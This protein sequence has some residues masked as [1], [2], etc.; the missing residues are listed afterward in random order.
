[1]KQWFLMLR[2][3]VVFLALITASFAQTLVEGDISGVWNMEGSPYI[4]T[5]SVCVPAEDTLFIEPGVEV[6][7]RRLN[8]PIMFYVLGCLIAHGTEEDSI[9]FMSNEDEPR[10]ADWKYIYA[11]EGDLDLSYLKITDSNSGIIGGGKLYVSHCKIVNYGWRTLPGVISVGEPMGICIVMESTVIIR[12]CYIDGSNERFSGGIRTFS[13]I[14][15]TL[16]IENCIIKHTDEKGIGLG[17]NNEQEMSVM[18]ISDCVLEDCGTGIGLGEFIS[19]IHIRNNMFI[20]CRKFGFGLSRCRSRIVE[21]SDNTFYR[22]DNINGTAITIYFEFSDDEDVEEQTGEFRIRNNVINGWRLGLEYRGDWRG[23]DLIREEL[24]IHFTNNTVV[25]GSIPILIRA[26]NNPVTVRNNIFAFNESEALINRTGEFPVDYNYNLFWNGSLPVDPEYSTR[27]DIRMRHES[28]YADPCFVSEDDFHLRENSPAIDRGHPDSDVGGEPRPNGG[29]INLGAYGGTYEAAITPDE[30]F[31][32]QPT[33]YPREFHFPMSNAHWRLMEYFN[34]CNVDDEVVRVESFRTSNP[35]RFSFEQEGGFDVEPSS[36]SGRLGFAFNPM[37]AGIFKDTLFVETDKGVISSLIFARTSDHIRL[38]GELSGT[39]HKVLSPFYIDYGACVP[40][41]STL[42]IEAGVELCFA[43]YSRFVCYG[44]MIGRGQPGDSIKFTS[45][46][47]N[48]YPGIWESI[49]LHQDECDLNYFVME[50][51]DRIYNRDRN[52]QLQLRNGRVQY[53]SGT[54]LELYEGQNTIENLIIADCNSGIYIY[55]DS[56][57]VNNISFIN[58]EVGCWG[59]ISRNDLSRG[60]RNCIFVNNDVS[61]A[62]NA[63]PDNIFVEYDLFFNNGGIQGVF[64]NRNC[65]HEDPILIGSLHYPYHLAPTSPCINAGDPDYPND[66]DGTRSDIGAIPFNFDNEPPEIDD[67]SPDEFELY[68]LPENP[69]TFR[70]EVFDEEG[71][72]IDYQWQVNDSVFWGGDSLIWS[73][74]SLGAYTVSVRA[75]DGYNWTGT[76]EWTVNVVLDVDTEENDIP[77]KFE[78]TSLY[79]NPFNSST[80][81]SYSLPHPGNLSIILYD[82]QGRSITQEVFTVSQAGRFSKVFDLSE[83]PTGVYV[84]EMTFDSIVKRQKLVLIR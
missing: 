63:I 17:P 46:S 57:N 37:E 42:T 28:I 66:P 33:I 84:L 40:E 44:R 31:D 51:G 4:V 72:F 47:P 41:G 38:R 49:E 32:T 8:V 45:Y 27:R 52:L 77:D 11:P 67:Y 81:V 13:G 55:G 3:V 48:P 30:P 61:L 80:K 54:F 25:N 22:T 79:P 26:N 20:N 36:Y 75:I 65:L 24:F 73:F 16:I 10:K 14:L 21:V 6:K 18:Q 68:Q 69:V 9:F 7:F 59:Y 53:F 15:D 58:N 1:M 64:N 12:D 50:Y 70:V 56:V 60:L 76:L 39:L 5:D 34:V 43:D 62:L 19:D 29:R 23:G 2:F 74:D 82:L 35:D 78:L 83:Y 71:A